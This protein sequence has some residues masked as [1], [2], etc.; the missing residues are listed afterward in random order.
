M[1][2]ANDN[3]PAKRKN[4]LKDIKETLMEGSTPTPKPRRRRS[5]PGHTITG[6][7][8]VIGDGNTVNYYHEPP[9][10]QKKV[11]VKT[12]DGVL[13]ATQ[14][15]KIN[16][17][18][19]DW[20][21]ARDAVRK[22]TVEI[23]S[24]R[25][26]FNKYMSVNSYHEIKQEDFDKAIKWLQR[27]MGIVNSMPSAASKNPNW[28]KSRYTSIKAKCNEFDGGIERQKKYITEKYGVKSLTELTDEQL[29]STYR[30]VR[31]WR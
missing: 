23:R 28:R 24:L 6:N 2:E 17:L 5:T 27:Q 29:E 9:V 22:S 30:H 7:G 4:S 1:T 16:D 13:T 26:A 3:S 11:Y 21:G 19:K 31:G 18:F 20:M 15:A 8:N 14:K 25:A 10:V 12:G